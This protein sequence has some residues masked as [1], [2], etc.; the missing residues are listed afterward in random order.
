MTD[1]ILILGAGGFV[2]QA[3]VRALSGSGMPVIAAARSA[4]GIPMHPLVEPVVG[5]LTG[6]AD[7]LPL[8]ARSRAVVH[9]ATTSTPGTSAARPLNEID[10]NLRLTGTLLR[11]LQERPSVD[12]LY[13]SSGGSLYRDARGE[14]ASEASPVRPRSY[15][16]AAKLAA[17]A[18]ISAWCDQFG[19]A[20]TILRPSNVYGPMQPER[21]GFGIVPTAFGKALRNEELQIWGD[22]SASRDYV[23][24]DD[25]VRLCLLTLAR[26]MTAGATLVN[27]CSGQSTSLNTLLDAIDSTT[28][29]PLRRVYLPARSVDASSI[30]MDPAKALALYGWRHAT[31]LPAGIQSAWDSYVAS[32]ATAP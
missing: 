15:H 32:V 19:G 1:A 20:A 21:P 12:L 13:L 18:F 25:L 9:L 31:G 26:P 30:A 4:A 16:G 8:V 7:L 23:F 17:E 6:E 5:H 3:L 24:I 27:A 28:G 14:P 22:G 11:A 10:T 2:G 29:R